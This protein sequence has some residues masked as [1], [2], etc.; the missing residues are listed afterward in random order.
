MNH[1]TALGFSNDRKFEPPLLRQPVSR[2]VTKHTGIF[3]NTKGQKKK[4]S[5][6]DFFCLRH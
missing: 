2:T 1:R 3:L 4:S 6:G 5:N